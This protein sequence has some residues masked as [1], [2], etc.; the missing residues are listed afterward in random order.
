ML[1]AQSAYINFKAK[2][3]EKLGMQTGRI[4]FPR[5]SSKNEGTLQ[6]NQEVNINSN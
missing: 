6:N 5:K 4:H 3:Y 2:K 1:V